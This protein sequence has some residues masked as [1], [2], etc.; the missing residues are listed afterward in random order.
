MTTGVHQAR[1]RPGEAE[2][3]A[4]LRMPVLLCAFL[5][6]TAASAFAQGA[7][8]TRSITMIVP[9]AAGG[10][11]DVLARVVAEQMSTILGQR[12][13]NENIAGAGGSTAL[14]RAARAEPDGYTIAIGNAGT[15]AATYTIYNDLAFK[16]DAFVAVAMVAKTF[17]LI[18]LKKDFPAKT[19]KEFLAY[20]KANPGKVTLGHA[21]IGSSNYLI[22]QTFVKA[23][24]IEATLVGYRGAG[25]AL[26]DL[27]GGQID[28]VCDTATS[29]SGAITCKQVNGIISGSTVRL[30]SLPDVPTAVEAGLPEFESQ[31]WNA[32]FVPKGTP[33]AVVAK[34]NEAARKALATEAVTKRFA[35]LSSVVPS[36][37]EQTQP[38][39]AKLVPDEIE[40]FRKLLDKQ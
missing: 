30:P 2:V 5:I 39:I 19:L 20:A 4:F 15:N 24:G 12:I 27:I 3:I 32:L 22:C 34:L 10:T 28:G 16:P 38:F 21:G 1:R 9:F 31:G 37:E 35:D 26:N 6:S 36:A 33:D 23:A 40:K 18:A 14:A 25:P 7:Y 13:I 17:G 29:L 8:P 11:S